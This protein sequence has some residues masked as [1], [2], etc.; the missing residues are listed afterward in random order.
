MSDNF[1]L[2]KLKRLHKAILDNAGYAHITA[3]NSGVITSFNHA[4][5]KMLGYKA[6]ELIGKETP[7]IFH[8]LDEVVQRAKEFS[9]ILRREIQPGFETFVCL[10]DALLPNQHEWTYIH[11]NGKRF[12]VQL[13][14]TALR[15]DEGVIEGYLGIASDISERKEREK[16]VYESHLKTQMALKAKTEFLANMSHEIRSPM[17]GVLGMVQ[18]LKTTKLSIE[19][20]AMLE[21]IETSGKSLLV[22]LNDILDIS[23]IES[24]KI[25]LEKIPFDI[26]KCAQEAISLFSYNSQEKEVELKINFSGLKHDFYKGDITRIRQVLVNLLSN[27]IKFTPQ[28]EVE[29]ILRNESKNIIIEIKDSGVGIAKDKQ[30]NL[31]QAFTQAD[32]S[33]TRKYGGTGLGLAICS[34]LVQLMNGYIELE[35]EE[36]KGSLFRV[37]LKLM[38]ASSEDLKNHEDKLVLKKMSENYPHQILLTED[39][40]VNQKVCSMILSKLGY[41]CDIASNGKEALKKLRAGK[42]YTLILMDLQMPEMD[43]FSATSEILKK[44]K[45]SSPIIIIALTA[46]AYEEDRKRCQEVGMHGFLS[47]P[48]K[49]EEL[50]DVLKK[51]YRGKLT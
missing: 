46:N 5:E 24:G 3:T 32:S 47:K 10:T 43:G 17:N 37:V 27:A 33:I 13:N 35:S 49:I 34:Q 18:L 40:P 42:K 20:K 39:N 8:D 14:I 16:E 38:E 6:S 51:H 48:I 30:K 45:D 4:A 44:Y 29:L 26:K 23:K 36:G 28:G 31:F 22:I 15:N 1:D 41:Q 7:A 11:K 2:D 25:D 50:V 21:T 9:L 19:Q 12:P